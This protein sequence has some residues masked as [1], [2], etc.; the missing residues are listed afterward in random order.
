[1]IRAHMSI[2]SINIDYILRPGMLGRA[3]VP[4]GGSGSREEAQC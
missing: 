3:A 2:E 4:V 1:M